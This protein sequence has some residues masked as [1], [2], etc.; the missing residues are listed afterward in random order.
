MSNETLIVR[1]NNVKSCG[2]AAEAAADVCCR[3]YI[4]SCGL[5]LLLKCWRRSTLIAVVDVIAI[6][7]ALPQLS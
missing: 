6:W 2:G 3:E 4:H 7:A 5:F 1:Y